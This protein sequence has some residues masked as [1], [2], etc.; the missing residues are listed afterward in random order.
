MSK[1]IS[2]AID[3]PAGAGKSTMA[4]RV[5]KELGYVYVDTGAIYRTV[6]YH[7]AL[8]GVGPK[9]VDGI[10]RLIDDVNIEIRYAQDGQQRMI[11]NGQDVT[12]ELRDQKMSDYASKIAVMKGVRDYL[13]DLQRKLAKEYDV[14]MDGRDIGTV[15]LPKANVKIF[16][17][18]SP[19][20]R[21]KRRLAELLEK[22]SKKET[23]EKVLEDIKQRDE[24][25]MNREIAPLK[26]A[27]DAVKLDTSALSIEESVAAM[28]EIIGK[29]LMG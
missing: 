9:D 4:R 14:V 16:L 13:L 2:V 22:G 8:Y 6:G 5:A 20:V 1:H 23:Y 15:V 26:C 27:A 11:L 19:E 18:A 7:M 24:R 12:E 28:K 10:V 17:T 3:G 25:D 21:A 29:K